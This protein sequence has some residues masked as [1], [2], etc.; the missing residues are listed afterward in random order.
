[1]SIEKPLLFCLPATVTTNPLSPWGVALKNWLWLE[2]NQGEVE[3]EE[4]DMWGVFELQVQWSVASTPHRQAAS[5]VTIYNEKVHWLLVIYH[6]MK[7][8]RSWCKI[9]FYNKESTAVTATSTTTATKLFLFTS[10]I[11]HF[12]N[13]ATSN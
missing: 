13:T 5:L 8:Y 7:W 10:T 11:L 2:E 9:S 1:M 6:V 12:T 4:N 3:V